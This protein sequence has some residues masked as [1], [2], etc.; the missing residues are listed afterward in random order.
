MTITAW[1]IVILLALLIISIVINFIF[2]ILL[3]RKRAR[4]VNQHNKD[5]INKEILI[6]KVNDMSVEK[7]RE[8]AN[9][10]EKANDIS[11]IANIFSNL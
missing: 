6:K 10:I 3:K 7:S 4:T 9:E 1:I 2:G 5:V 11:A 8:V